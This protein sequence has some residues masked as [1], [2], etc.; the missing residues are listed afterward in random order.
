MLFGKYHIVI[1]R[2]K[3]GTSR[4]LRMRGVSGL[5]LFLCIVGLIGGNIWLWQNYRDSL[6]LRSRLSEAERTIEDQN[7]HLTAMVSKLTGLQNDLDRVQQFDSKL[8]LMMNMERDPTDVSAM[9]GPGSDSFSRTYLPI[10]RQE[11]MVRKMNVFLK[12]LAV[13]TQLEEVRQQELLRTLRKNRDVLASMPS[14]WPIEGFITSRFGNRPSP[15]TGRG[16]EFHKGLDISARIGTPIYAPGKGT[17]TFAGTDGGYGNSVI[18]Q[19]GSGITTRYAHMQRFVVKDGQQ[20][21]RGDI[22]GYVG[23]TGRTTGPHLHYEVRLNGA[24]VDPMRYI[25]N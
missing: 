5:L 14:I 8:R 13:E 11:L 20:V 22:I 21:K 1:F 16:G 4:N 3:S 6:T 10:H 23:T 15:F 19:H 9:G 24:N 25:L 12:Q 17:V 7:T 2:E 18:I